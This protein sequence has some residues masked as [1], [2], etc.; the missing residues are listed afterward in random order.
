MDPPSLDEDYK[1]E[2]LFA[3]IPDKDTHKALTELFKLS[4]GR[5]ASLYLR[6]SKTS[7]C[8]EHSTIQSEPL[9]L[10]LSNLTMTRNMP[11]SGANCLMS[12]S[13]SMG[14]ISAC[15]V[16][17]QSSKL[18]WSTKQRKIHT[19]TPSSLSAPYGITV[20]LALATSVDK[21]TIEYSTH[22]VHAR[23]INF[24]AELFRTWFV[25]WLGGKGH[26][27]ELVGSI[28]TE[29]MYEQSRKSQKMQ[30]ELFWKAVSDLE[31]LPGNSKVLQ[32]FQRVRNR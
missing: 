28:V 30:A 14:F 31:A 12:C 3:M 32:L 20:S 5:K 19:F 7:S 4:K 16:S 15:A 27:H 23:L 8:V 2:Y 17:G 21:S 10:I 24:F 13:L 1:C 18:L 26:P 6:L 11:T 25:R 22:S 29:E 9:P